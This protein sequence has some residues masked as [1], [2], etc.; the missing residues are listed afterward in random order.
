VI[1][2]GYEGPKA[3]G[4]RYDLVFRHM[5]LQKGDTL[6]LRIDTVGPRRTRPNGITIGDI[7][8]TR[9][10]SE[11]SAQASMKAPAKADRKNDKAKDRREQKRDRRE[12][13]G[14]KGRK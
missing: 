9:D 4:K 11:S 13:K 1:R 6:R 12:A 5:T 8:F 7:C 10:K 3:N 2:L 14:G